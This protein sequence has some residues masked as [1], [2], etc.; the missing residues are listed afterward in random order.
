[1]LRLIIRLLMILGSICVFSGLEVLLSLIF[2]LILSFFQM[3]KLGGRDLS[4]NMGGD[5][6]RVNLFVLSAWVVILIMI[7]S[8]KEN[9]YDNKYFIFYLQFML[10][11]LFMCFFSL[12]LIIF[13]FFFEAILFP[14][15]IIIF[16]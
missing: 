1:M 14:I 10:F 6:I 9:L 2:L 15:I 5:L 13:Y 8:F 3:F 7:A 4:L 12:N 16:N 11:L